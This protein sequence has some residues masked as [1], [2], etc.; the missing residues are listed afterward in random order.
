MLR[1]IISIIWPQRM[2]YN[3][4]HSIVEEEKK[5]IISLRRRGEYWLEAVVVD[6]EDILWRVE[7][8]FG[9]SKFLVAPG[10]PAC[11]PA[12]HTLLL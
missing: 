1:G 11:P 9:P 8:Y 5:D 2:S 3:G 4:F 10:Q 12:L 7:Q 6:D